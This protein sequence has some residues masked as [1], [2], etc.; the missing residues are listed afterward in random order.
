MERS[1]KIHP[2]RVPELVMEQLMDWIMD[3]KLNMGQRLNT[4][5]LAQL[6]GVSRMPVREAIKHLEKLGIVESVPY[7]GARLVTITKSDIQQIYMMRKKLEPVLGYHAC[8]NGTDEQ[9]AEAERIQDRF[10]LI[11][12]EGKPTAKEVFV[13]NRSFHFAIFRASGMER[14]ADTVCMLWHTLAF[15]KLIYGQT[16]VISPKAAARMMAEHR[17]YLDALHAR[18]AIHLQSLMTENLS[19]IE[20]ELPEKLAAYL[21]AESG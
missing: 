2:Q 19:R 10:E 18:D 13:Q 8:L 16:Y 7:A 9:I 4:E 12:R 11:M 3:G 14:I 15:C 20:V 17:S 21:N 6:M 5:E 1:V